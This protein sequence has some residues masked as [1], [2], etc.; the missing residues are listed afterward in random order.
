M[1]KPMDQMMHQAFKPRSILYN[2]GEQ[3]VRSL[4]SHLFLTN[5]LPGRGLRFIECGTCHGVSASLFSQ[6]GRVDTVDVE[7]SNSFTY[8]VRATGGDFEHIRRFA[9]PEREGRILLLDHLTSL[10]FD[11]GFE[12]A[13]HDLEDIVDNFEYLKRC[14]LVLFH[15][16]DDSQPDVTCFLDSLVSAGDLVKKVGTFGIWCSEDNPLKS[17]VLEL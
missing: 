13:S 1:S 3:V 6:F 17:K 2:D 10:P 15:D 12:D 5:G 4:L 8:V 14:G 9:C 7:L 16:Y 11:L